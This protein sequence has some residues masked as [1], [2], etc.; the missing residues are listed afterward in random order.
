[1]GA[2][3]A[4]YAVTGA[5]LLALAKADEDPSVIS[6]A[7]IQIGLKCTGEVPQA[8]SHQAVLTEKGKPDWPGLVICQLL[9]DRMAGAV[10]IKS[11]G[12]AGR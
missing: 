8:G 5:A 3:N 9:I 11:S 6:A 4:F 10:L 1:M 7:Q 2:V 12:K